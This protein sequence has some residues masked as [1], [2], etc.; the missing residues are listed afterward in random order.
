MR[1]WLQKRMEELLPVP[2]YHTIF[3][4]SH[5]FDILVP[6]NERLFY[7]ALFEAAGYSLNIM[8]RKY[9]GG[10]FGTTAVLHTWGQQLQRHIHL[11]CLVTGGALS[12]DHKRWKPISDKFLVDVK[13]LAVV[14][15]D[16]FCHIIRRYRR[17]AQLTFKRQAA[18]LASS[19]AFETFMQ[20][21]EGIA[22]H[23]YCQPPF[24]GPETV[25]EYLS[26]YSHR[27]AI[28][29]RRIL[30]VANGQVCFSYKDYQ[31]V[32]AEKKPKVKTEHCTVEEF[33]R[34]FLLHTLPKGFQK[35]RY[36]GFL[37]GGHR[38]QKIALCREL[39]RM[40]PSLP[41]PE[42]TTQESESQTF[43]PAVCPHCGGK[44]VLKEELAHAR[45]GP[46]AEDGQCKAA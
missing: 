19:H 35:I 9:H 20:E 33:M 32:D 14:F 43:E 8:S 4:I 18:Y 17:K 15:R 23:V 25:V 7:D 41:V 2:Y 6:Y 5:G 27:V 10:T 31:D 45:A 37:A 29:N 12:I 46:Q 34:R 38:H 26:R 40:H 22:W 28:S 42:E 16:R 11:H 39:I 1:K 24:A 44:L 13:E 30:S 3:T 36:F 21:Q